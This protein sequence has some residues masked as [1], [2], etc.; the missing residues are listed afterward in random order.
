MD[1]CAASAERPRPALLGVSPSA[2]APSI[3][4][5][6]HKIAR[7]WHLDVSKEK[8]AKDVFGHVSRAQEILMDAEQRRAY[9]FVLENR[10]PLT[11]PER[12][13]H[14]YETNRIGV[15]VR[16]LSRIRHHVGWAIAGS[17]GVIGLG[18]RMA[19]WHRKREPPT[20]PSSTAL[21]ARRA[22]RPSPTRAAS[23]VAHRGCRWLPRRANT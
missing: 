8:D 11:A 10:L 14:F 13:Q 17:L 20:A 9:D 3:K 7:A 23:R 4:K 22:S 2:D 21:G 15:N 1:A 18:V 5:A 16:R 19:W 6:Y 12:F